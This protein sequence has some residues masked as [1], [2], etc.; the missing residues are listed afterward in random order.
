[1][2]AGQSCWCAS[3]NPSCRPS[4]KIASSTNCA[5][6]YRSRSRAGFRPATAGG[7]RNTGAGE[8]LGYCSRRMAVIATIRDFCSDDAPAINRVALEAWDQYATV[9]NNWTGMAEFVGNIAS[10]VADLQLIVADFEGSVVGLVGYV[11]LYAKREEMFPPEWAVIRMLSVSPGARGRGLGRRLSEECI[12]RARRDS[13]TA[14]GLHTSPAM[15]VALPLYL[16]LGFVLERCIPGPKRSSVRALQ[17][18]SM[19]AGM[20]SLCMGYCGNLKSI[21][22]ARGQSRARTNARAAVARRGYSQTPVEIIGAH[23]LLDDPSK[24]VALVMCR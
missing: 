15:E 21:P 18:S 4:S 20:W 22:M 23:F 7:L 14:I 2:R 12:A 24:V 3:T 1:M 16:R 9:F 17:A 6:R 13:A 8:S 19:T 5:H 10:L 11:P